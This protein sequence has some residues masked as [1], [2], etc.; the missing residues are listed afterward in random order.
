M[1]K[2][3]LI[4]LCHKISLE[5]GLTFNSVLTYYFLEIFL[6]KLSES[7][8]NDNFIFKGGYILSNIVGLESRST[9]DIDMLI[10]NT[11]LDEAKVFTI[12]LDVIKYK[13]KDVIEY[14]LL[15]IIEIKKEGSY[16]GYRVRISC[17]LDNIR[18]VIP[19]DIATGDIITYKPI[20]YEYKR[21]FSEE[22]LNIKAYN[23][24]T[25]LAEKLETI[26]SKGMLNSRSK[27]FYDV[28]LLYNIKK[29][30][31]DFAKLA[32]A[33]ERTFKQRNTPLD[34]QNLKDL[35]EILRIDQGFNGRWKAY[36][37]KN[38]YIDDC[39]FDNVIE[40]IKDLL[41]ATFG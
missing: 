19:L 25:M 3:K 15:D 11:I 33:C 26:Y 30:D 29:S 5:T 4:S 7:I 34:S 6:E 35:L 18:Q 28:H 32:V 40:S 12:I 38:A 24:E 10:K 8:Y 13:P 39:S 16:G 22:S 31:I 23:L 1:N 21:I 37:S 14:E 20:E 41:R 9:V 17:K 36:A 27:D 2:D